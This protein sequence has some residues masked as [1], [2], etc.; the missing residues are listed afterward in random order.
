VSYVVAGE[1]IFFLGDEQFH[2]G[3]GDIFTVPP[4]IPHTVQLL[5]GHVRLVDTFHPLRDDFLK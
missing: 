5:S 3:P 1:I 2:L 4:E